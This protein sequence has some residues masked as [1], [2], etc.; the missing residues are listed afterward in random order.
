MQN[1]MLNL[2]CNRWWAD[3]ES[4]RWACCGSCPH[5]PVHLLRTDVVLVDQQ[6]ITVIPGCV[7]DPDGYGL[8]ETPGLEGPGIAQLA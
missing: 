1:S 6:S 4:G 3:G 2:A 7:S 8:I 5:R